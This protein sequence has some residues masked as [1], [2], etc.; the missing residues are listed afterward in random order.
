MNWLKYII[1]KLT[2]KY[3][4]KQNKIIEYQFESIFLN[5][6]NILPQQGNYYGYVKEPLGKYRF[7]G[8]W[9]H[10]QFYF[11]IS[12]GDRKLGRIYV[13]YTI[14][15]FEKK[16]RWHS[17]N[18]LGVSLTSKN[19]AFNRLELALAINHVVPGLIVSSTDIGS[20]IENRI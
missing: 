14:P 18:K 7:S 16:L 6:D 15:K 9:L 20:V 5:I 11:D 12:K 10:S 13:G 17:I 19:E 2:H 4:I 3:Q 1:S 8:G